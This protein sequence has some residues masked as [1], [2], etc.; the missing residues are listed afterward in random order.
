MLTEERF[1]EILRL[2][3]KQKAVTVTEL[4]KLLG[5]SES[6]I[7]RDL[8]VLHERGLINK[9][10]GGATALQSANDIYNTA[11]DTVSQKRSQNRQEKIRIAHYAATLVHAGD[12][13]YLDAGTSTDALID[14]LPD[15]R[16]VFV[17][18][19]LAHAQRLV[20]RGFTTYI[21]GG[22]FKL[23][24]EAIVGS[25]AL[26]SLQKYNFTKG[27]FG[28]NGISPLSGFSTPDINEAM[29]KTKAMSRCRERFVLSD[30]SKFNKISSI[31]F[32]EFEHATVITTLLN[33][34]NYRNCKNIVEVDRL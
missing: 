29:V 3:D 2:V 18:N 15:T 31:T 34:S 7:R 11:E 19:A 23:A 26:S 21:L 4:T 28:T 25:E 32:E 9:V 27:F 17:T 1:S 33:D 16:A 30:S 20:Q 8:N 6:T 5:A 14:Y 13:V 22:Q 24:T 12:F 10:H